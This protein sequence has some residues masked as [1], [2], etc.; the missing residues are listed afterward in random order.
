MPKFLVRFSMRGFFAGFFDPAP[1]LPNFGVSKIGLS[2]WMS[3]IIPWGN[4][5]GAAFFPFGGMMSI[6]LIIENK[7]LANVH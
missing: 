4:G 2:V 5:A 7:Q 3:R 1:A 6:R